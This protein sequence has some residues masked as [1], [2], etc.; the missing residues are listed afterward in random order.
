MKKEVNQDIISL[1]K[2][3]IKKNNYQTI[4]ELLKIWKQ[5][6]SKFPEKLWEKIIK[7]L[8]YES[9]VPIEGHIL[10]V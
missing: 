2:K 8:G 5:K 4:T 9:K 6:A 1:L 7:Q 3:H 10:T